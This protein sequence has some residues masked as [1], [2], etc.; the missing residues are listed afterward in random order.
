M[1]VENINL[2][3]L[4]IT[5]ITDSSFCLDIKLLDDYTGY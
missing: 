3:G 1:E 4:V 2:G 5:K